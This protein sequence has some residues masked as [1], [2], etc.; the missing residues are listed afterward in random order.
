MARNDGYIYMIE[1][2]RLL[3]ILEEMEAAAAD[4]T[5][6]D[7]TDG[8]TRVEYPVATTTREMMDLIADMPTVELV[9]CEDCE[10]W[11][12]EEGATCGKCKH[13]STDAVPGIIRAIIHM[14]RP[15][16]Y[17][18]EAQRRETNGSDIRG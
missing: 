2:G 7:G 4:G 17:C 18:S 16:D 9:R 3:E 14:T 5:E 15:D 12:A 13:W 1:R 11:Q 6:N 10:H 8:T